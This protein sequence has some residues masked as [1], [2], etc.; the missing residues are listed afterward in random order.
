LPIQWRFRY[1]RSEGRSGDVR[2]SHDAGSNKFQAIFRSRLRYLSQ[3]EQN[4]WREPTIKT[5][6]GECRGLSEIRFKGD[7][8][9]QRPLGFV[10]G[11]YEFTLLFWATEKN[12]RFVPK[13][14][15]ATAIGWKTPVIAD[16]SLADALWFALE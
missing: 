1:Y 10:S 15:C 7:G 14:A 2:V 4:E 12:N 6:H 9:E 11:R 3:L 8:V 16:R 5:L 13:S